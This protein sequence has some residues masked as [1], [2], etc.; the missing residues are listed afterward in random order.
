M[1]VILLKDNFK[2][3]LSIVEKI[4]GKNL[5]LPILNNVLIAAEKNFLGLSTTDL[6]IAIRYW[7]L[8]K[9]EEEGKITIPAKLLSSLVNFISDE[10]ITLEIKNQILQI[11]HK[12]NINQINGLSSEEF[13][14]IP[15][16]ERK[17]SIEVNSI[18][19]CQGLAQVIDFCAQTQIR[20][21]IS[22]IYF[23]IQKDKISLAATDSFRL[24]EKIIL[25]GKQIIENQ[26][27]SFILPQ[28]A[29]RE[30][31]NIF[32]A[33][34]QKIKIFFSNNQVMFEYPLTEVDHPQV[35]VISRLID[36]QYPNYIEIIPTKYETE[37][38]VQKEEFLNQIKA[39]SL[40]SGK[41]NEI[42]I[43]T[44][45]KKEGIEILS[46]NT[47]IGENKSFMPCKIEGKEA[48][49]S[50]NYRFLIDGLINMKSQEINLLLS[51]EEGPAVL[52]PIGDATY[53]YVVMPIKK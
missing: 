38:V 21:E 5:N 16:I 7:I 53:T 30:L 51:G 28:K 44:N 27:S 17:N 36:G 25:F 18:P 4:V 6:E 42:Q 8:V 22:G 40:F 50:F 41:T 24:A 15:K 31:I 39:A 19:F 48:V 13:P 29:A 52:K 10:K 35:Q 11:Q 26:E 23:N 1:K 34:D 14:I 43:K 20:P 46:Q 9:T 33:G 49:I 2:K 47:D 12:E 3:G 37:I 45:I 32:S